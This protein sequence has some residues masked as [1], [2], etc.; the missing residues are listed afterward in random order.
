M[1]GE[2][3][4]RCPLHPE[5]PAIGICARCGTFV[6]ASCGT[7]RNDGQLSCPACDERTPQLELA[8]RG[9]RFWANLV[10]SF[11]VVFPLI[12]AGFVS[13]FMR[14]GTGVENGADV[15]LIG[16]GLGGVVSV[17]VLG[18]QLSLARNGQSIGKKMGRIR[19]VRT[20]GG[21][22]TLVT[23]I[24]LRNLIPLMARAMPLIGNFFGIVDAV[25]IF[26]E[27]RQ[28]LHDVIASTMVIKVQPEAR[29]V[30]P[31]VR[32]SG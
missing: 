14:Q 21:P 25:W 26:G 27:R 2:G 31:E 18:F 11:L 9:T 5:A 4:A 15:M 22:A 7:T 30:S 32:V 10:D 28:C 29:S 23:I 20:D 12:A 6:C 1:V 13:G 8:D 24:F 19:V 3:T 16:M 17:L